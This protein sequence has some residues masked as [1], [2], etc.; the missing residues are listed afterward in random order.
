MSSSFAAEALACLE[1]VKLGRDLGLVNAILEGD[2]LTVV[3]KCLSDEEDRS[4]LCAYIKNIKLALH[5]MGS[6]T[7]KHVRRSA[8]ILA[9][10]I[11]NESLKTQERFFLIGSVPSYAIKAL[12]DDSI[13]EPD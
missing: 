2:S 5:G 4:E 12:M 13:R 10:R 1:A 7:L 11:A 3:K 6:W 9:D 8:N